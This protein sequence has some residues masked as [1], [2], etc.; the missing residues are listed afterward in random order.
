LLGGLLTAHGQW[1]VPHLAARLVSDRTHLRELLARLGDVWRARGVRRRLNEIERVERWRHETIA[2][3][4][5]H[6]L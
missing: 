3:L 6:D 1:L 4:A 2:R 5:G